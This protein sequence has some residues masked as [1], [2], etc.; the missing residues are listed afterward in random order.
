MSARPNPLP[1]LYRW[2]SNVLQAPLFLLGTAVCATAALLISAVDKSGRAQHRIA[3]L[4]ARGVVRVSLSRLTV[5]GAENL[6]RHRVAVYASNHTSYMDTPVIFASLPFQFR[7]LAKK[8]LWQMPFIGWYLGRSGQMPI[9]TVNPHATRASLGE[10][11][12]VLRAGMPLFVFPEGGRTPTGK[13]LP[14]LSGAAYLAIRAQVPLVPIA[15]SGVYDLMPIH[16]HHIYPG[17]L[18]LRA[19]E[20]IETTGMT[21]RQTGELTERLRGAIQEMLGQLARSDADTPMPVA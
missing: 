19:G 6:H 21:V 3:Q 11:V 15:L 5:E 16:T 4:W 13:L 14:F 8:E 2:R 17:K 7:I 20:P 10:G 12:K 1:L 9:D 18:T